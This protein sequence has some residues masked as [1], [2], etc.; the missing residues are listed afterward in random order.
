[1]EDEIKANAPTQRAVFANGLVV[2]QLTNSVLGKPKTRHV[3]RGKITEKPRTTSSNPASQREITLDYGEAVK[4][5]LDLK[6]KELTEQKRRAQA[7][8]PLAPGPLSMALQMPRVLKSFRF[9]TYRRLKYELTRCFCIWYNTKVYDHYVALGSFKEKSIVYIQ[10]SWRGYIARLHVSRRKQREAK[11]MVS[12]VN[13]VKRLYK[14][15][16]LRKAIK[17]RIK[18]R[19]DAIVFPTATAI[20]S[21]VRL[22]LGRRA[23]L[24]TA[25]RELYRELR[26]WSGGRVDSLLRRPGLQDLETQYLIISAVNLATGTLKDSITKHGLRLRL[27]ILK[28]LRVGEDVHDTRIRDLIIAYL[29]IVGP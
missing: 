21:I 28:Y 3:C 23:F 6:L 19:Q 4:E 5:A 1:M 22:Y 29:Y 2:T 25:K 8:V 12:A 11:K 13:V 18:E 17:A 16:R 27:V 24:L 10:R 26:L 9:I 14:V 20:Q 15:Y 7:K